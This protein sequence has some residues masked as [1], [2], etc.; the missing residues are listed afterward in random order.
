MGDA[1]NECYDN[2]L[3][4]FFASD[5]HLVKQFLQNLVD[6]ELHILVFEVRG[7][8]EKKTKCCAVIRR[9]HSW[10][11][12]ALPESLDVVE[13]HDEK[14]F[15]SSL[16]TP[17]VD[18]NSDIVLL[19]Y[20][21][22]AVAVASRKNG[23][24]KAWS[25]LQNADE[26]DLACPAGVTAD[27][28][29]FIGL[30]SVDGKMA[31]AMEGHQGQSCVAPCNGCIALSADMIN[32]QEYEC[33]PRTGQYSN[34]TLYQ[35][36]QEAL[37]MSFERSTHRTDYLKKNCYG[38]RWRELLRCTSKAGID[39]RLY[40]AMHAFQGNFGHI[41]EILF[42]ELTDIDKESS[43]QVEAGNIEKQII[44]LIQSLMLPIEMP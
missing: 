32:G 35:K 28:K 29:S 7:E 19:R 10:A 1:A 4:C 37:L 16:D 14:Y 25:S 21:G 12:V 33:H 13:V 3:K 42:D 8:G 2:L 31:S 5:T 6:D 30:V 38:I 27:P 20:R 11:N 26:A 43:L 41:D 39:K 22:K 15:L 17:D 9:D 23:A 18:A 44:E 24:I 36:S 34:E 40:G